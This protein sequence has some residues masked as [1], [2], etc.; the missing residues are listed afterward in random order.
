VVRKGLLI[1]SGVFV[2]ATFLVG[3]FDKVSLGLKILGYGA[4]AIVGLLVGIAVLVFAVIVF[5]LLSR[6]VLRCLGFLKVSSPHG[7]SRTP[8]D[9]QSEH[10]IS[11]SHRLRILAFVC[12]TYL[13]TLLN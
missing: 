13:T 3:M 10:S 1:A 9:N 5:V 4:A 2:L 7:R 6:I 12:L 8:S 11:Q